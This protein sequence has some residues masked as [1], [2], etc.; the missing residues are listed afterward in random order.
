M[1]DVLKILGRSNGLFVH[2]E[3]RHGDL[4]RSTI[5]GRRVL[6]YGGAGSIGSQVVKRCFTCAPAALHVIDIC[7]NNLVE[8]V[9]DVRSTL[10]YIEGDTRFLPIAMNGVEAR[11]FV[12]SEAPYDL[13]FN[14]AAM[15]HVRSEKDPFSLMRMIATN[16]L[17]TRDTLALAEA[18][19]AK[20]YFAVSTDKAKN[21]ANLMGATKRIMEDFLFGRDGT[22]P[23]S[24]ARF[25]NVAFSDGSLLH[26]FKQR[27]ANGQP[28]SAPKD[29][30]RYFLTKEESGFLCMIAAA[31]GNDREIYFPRLDPEAHLIDFAEIARRFL[32]SS[33]FE[34]VE[35]ESEEDARS[36]APTLIPTGRWPCYFFNSDTSGEK[37]FEEFYGPSDDVDW[38]RHRAL[39]VIRAGVLSSSDIDRAQRFAKTIEQFR[40]A[41]TWS[42]SEIVAAVIEACPEL[43]H[44]ETGKFLDERM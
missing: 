10:G 23:V 24:T 20:K 32:I 35:M 2:E 27:L 11:A 42:K 21:P 5:Q 22:T 17:D 36:L 15:K 25:A 4:I 9:R 14:L 31:L 13:V 41:G 29:I 28:I 18:A 7:E 1:N 26:G 33:G 8:L 34:P 39:G 30:K 38:Q 44:V 12:A 19:R 3:S 40:D 43:R 37:P 6:V 16:I